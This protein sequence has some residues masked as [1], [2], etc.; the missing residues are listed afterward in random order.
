MTMTP[1]LR[2]SL[3]AT[4]L[5][6]GKKTIDFQELCGL[7]LPV[8]RYFRLV[9]TEGRP[10]VTG[11]LLGHAGTFNVG[12]GAGGWKPFSSDQL[13]V[14]HPPGFDWDARI[15]LWPWLAV[16]VHDA[17][18]AG[19][20]ILHV[21]L[22]GGLTVADMRGGG[23]IAE[24]ELIRFLAEAAWYPTA[25]LPS[26]GVTWEAAGVDSARATLTDGE[27]SVSLTFHF[28]KNGAIDVVHADKRGRTVGKDI[29]DTPWEGRF[30]H[31]KSCH[32]M[33]LP[34]KGEASWMHPEGPQPYWRGTVE[35]IAHQFAE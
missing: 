26:E 23:R 6:I 22:P 29:V 13:V 32:G 12:K 33:Y 25:L 5:P 10:I 34:Y 16:R 35:T 7:P 30:W 8:Q 17:Y 27:V 11:A 21:A 1:I 20:G 3:L 15:V 24:G 4:R 2:A 18:I 28:K 9:L 14:V 19:I 31:Y